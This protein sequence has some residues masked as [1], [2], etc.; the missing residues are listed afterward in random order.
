MTLIKKTLQTEIETIFNDAANKAV[1][2]MLEKMK[3]ISFSKN[4]RDEIVAVT[5]PTNQEIA[6]EFTDNF[7]PNI[8]EKLTTAI[9]NYIK[10][11]TVTINPGITLTT[12]GTAAAQT[13]ATTSTG[14]GKI[15]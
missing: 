6:K 15:T 12:V 13:G 10:S 3:Q 2:A 11:G 7:V 4:K 8:S 9:D 1:I 14:T 5:V